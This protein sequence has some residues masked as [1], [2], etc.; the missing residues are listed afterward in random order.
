MLRFVIER[1]ATLPHRP[2]SNGRVP[3]GRDRAPT[4]AMGFVTGLLSGHAARGGDSSRFLEKCG[5]DSHALGQPQ[6]RVPLADY[7]NLYN[8]LVAELDDEAF[9]L[10]STPMRAGSFEFLTR[11]VLHSATLGE[12]LQHS[13]RFL[14]LV[15]PEMPL[16]VVRSGDT[17]RLIMSETADL[18]HGPNDPRRVFAFEWLL[19]LVHS[20]ACWLADRS[21]HLDSVTFPYSRPP[22]ADDYPLI[23]TAQAMFAGKQL[24]ASFAAEELNMPVRRDEA[25]LAEFLKGAPGRISIL[26]RRDRDTIRRVRDIIAATIPEPISLDQIAIELNISRRTLQRRLTEEGSSLRVIKDAIRRSAALAR[27]ERTDQTISQIAEELGY[28]DSTAFYRAFKGWMTEAPREYR[29]K[30]GKN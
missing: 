23:Y 11:G 1:R 6:V 24:V 3:R 27:L 25:A 22:Q 16:I 15:L 17:A 14:R 2:K 21:I 26:Y 10:F 19:R 13:A 4:V 20:L 28:S 12:A 9:G 29:Y 7:A 18:W 8:L 5:I 30:V